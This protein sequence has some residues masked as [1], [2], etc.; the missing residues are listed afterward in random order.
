MRKLVVWGGVTG[1]E[2]HRW[3]HYAFVQTGRK[4]GYKVAWVPDSE[5]S[6]P[7]ITPGS[8]VI[9]AN[10]WNQ[11][12]GPAI[13]GADYCLHNY[14]GSHVLC[15]TAEEGQLVRLQVWTYDSVGEEW[16][17][18]RQYHREGRILFQPWGTDLLAEEFM[19]PVFNSLSREVVFVGA[20]WSDMGPTGEM[21]NQEAI[22]ELRNKLRESGLSFRHLT[23]VSAQENIEA[24]RSARLAPS[25]VG[26]WQ[27]D[28]GYL[29]CRGFKNSSYGALMFTNSPA[30]Q[31]LYGRTADDSNGASDAVVFAL[32]LKKGEYE[33][34]VRAQQRVTARYTYRESLQ[35]IERALE[36]GK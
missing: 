28:H 14:D 17:T 36:E 29:P 21:G 25:I 8:L 24:V 2:S 16:D 10:V 3:I 19:D 13:D 34:R 6:R 30:M 4:L 15:Q 27:V 18:C 35:A 22:Y 20:V 9:S 11:N 23:Q 32:R 1:H 31:S 7:E 26:Q 5:Y 12:I 33:D